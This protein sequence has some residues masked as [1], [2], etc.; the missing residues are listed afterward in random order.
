[1]LL[2][3]VI[4]CLLVK[5][6]IINKAGEVQIPDAIDY[7]SMFID[8]K[9]KVTDLVNKCQIKKQIPYMDRALDLFLCYEV[10]KLSKEK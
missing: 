7:L 10:N 4:H 8:D 3:L 2:Q 5:L 1:M 9:E 6:E